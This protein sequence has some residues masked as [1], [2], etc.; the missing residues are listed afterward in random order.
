MPKKFR[1]FER[2]RIDILNLAGVGFLTL[3]LVAVVSVT[4][5]PQIKQIFAPK[6]VDTEYPLD[7]SKP[8]EIIPTVEPPPS[9]SPTTN[10]FTLDQVI[11]T[12]NHT[13]GTPGYDCSQ[14]GCGAGSGA[15]SGYY[16][17]NGRYYAIGGTGNDP[18]RYASTSLAAVKANGGVVS[19]SQSTQT[20][21]QTQ[22]QTTTGGF[23]KD[24]VINTKA[25]ANTAGY[26]M[27]NGN[28]AGY[29]ESNGRYYP[30]GG[31]NNNPIVYQNT[32]LATIKAEAAA[33]AEKAA[34]ANSIAVAEKRASDA[35]ARIDAA[36]K[37]AA[38]L[39]AKQS[40]ITVNQ[41]GGVSIK[42]PNGGTAKYSSDCESGNS[43][44]GVCQAATTTSSLPANYKDILNNVST[45][46][47]AKT[48]NTSPYANIYSTTPGFSPYG[49]LTSTSVFSNYTPSPTTNIQITPKTEQ[50]RLVET[51]NVL[52]TITFG[53]FGNYVGAYQ[54]VA[55]QNP[56]ASYLEQSFSREGLVASTKLGTVITAEGAAIA[57]L[58]G[59]IAA[60]TTAAAGGSVL[61][62]AGAVG[63]QALTTFGAISTMSQ[64]MNAAG[65]HIEDPGSTEAW[66]QTGL[67]ALS[68]LNLGSADYLMKTFSNAASTAQAINSAKTLNTAVSAVNLAV[69]VPTAYSTCSQEG[70]SA[71]DCGGAITAVVA[72]VG[73]GLLDFKQGQLS[74]G[75]PLSKVTDASPQKI[76]ASQ[77]DLALLAKLE[78]ESAKVP[79]ISTSPVDTSSTPIIPEQNLVVEPLDVP[80]TKLPET[81]ITP[82]VETDPNL[83]TKMTPASDLPTTSNVQAPNIP[84]AKVPEAPTMPVTPVTEAVTPVT[85]IVQPTTDTQ[86]STATKVK[87]F[88]VDNWNKITSKPEKNVITSTSGIEY[89]NVKPIT[90]NTTSSL[91]QVS[92]GTDKNGNQSVIKIFSETQIPGPLGQKMKDA[93]L[94][95]IEVL[96]NYS[97]TNPENGVL[98]KL[99]DTITDKTGA[100]KGYVMEEI[101]GIS[102]GDLYN[103]QGQRLTT[104]Q[105]DQIKNTVDTYHKVT[106]EM[107]ADLIPGSSSSQYPL[108]PGNIIFTGDPKRPVVLIDPSPGIPGT[109]WFQPT[110]IESEFKKLGERL[111]DV[112]TAP[113]EDS[114]LTTLIGSKNSPS[115][116][117]VATSPITQSV[118]ETKPTT[119]I[120]EGITDW[121]D[122]N[123]VQP[124]GNRIFGSGPILENL[125]APIPKVPP[126]DVQPPK[127]TLGAPL[128]ITEAE[129]IARLKSGEPAVLYHSLNDANDLKAIKTEGF[130]SRGD[131]KIIVGEKTYNLTYF[132]DV[133]P[134]EVSPESVV[135]EVRNLKLFDGRNV[136]SPPYRSLIDGSYD[137]TVYDGAIENSVSG[138][139]NSR[140]EVI[141]FDPSKSNPSA[142]LHPLSD[143]LPPE[144][145]PVTK[146]V[147]QATPTTNMTFVNRVSNYLDEKIVQPINNILPGGPVKTSIVSETST[148]I[149]PEVITSTP[150]EPFLAIA[151]PETSTKTWVDQMEIPIN[152]NSNLAKYSSHWDGKWNSETSELTVTPN[153]TSSTQNVGNKYYDTDLATVENGVVVPITDSGYHPLNRVGGRG[154]EFDI[155][156][157]EI[158]TKI[159]NTE[160]LF[161]GVNYEGM[162]ENLSGGMVTGGILNVSLGGERI[163]TADNPDFAFGYTVANDYF[164][165]PTF[166]KPGFVLVIE[167]P[168]TVA[169]VNGAEVII[170]GGISFDKVPYVYEIRPYVIESGKIKLQISADGTHLNLPETLD[171]MRTAP[172]AEFVYRKLSLDEAK[173]LFPEKLAP[174]E[175]PVVKV[176]KVAE[177]IPVA[178]SVAQDISNNVKPTLIQSLTNNSFLNKLVGGASVTI[179]TGKIVADNWDNISQTMT[180]LWQSLPFNKKAAPISPTTEVPKDTFLP[181]VDLL[182]S[183][184]D[185]NV[186]PTS[187]PIQQEAQIAVNQ[188]AQN[189][190]QQTSSTPKVLVMGDSITQNYL[191]PTLSDQLKTKGYSV[192]FVGGR[193]SRG[194]IPSEGHGGYNTQA[195]INSL[196][197]G[198]WYYQLDT[199]TTPP[200]KIDKDTDIVILELGVNDMGSNQSGAT[201]PNMKAIIK[202][203]RED[204]NPNI[205]IVIT[206]VPNIYFQDKDYY[207]EAKYLNNELNQMVSEISTSGSPV[208]MGD[209]YAAN[210]KLSQNTIDGVH[211]NDAGANKIAES[212]VSAIEDNQLI[213]KQ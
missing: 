123:V 110:D 128:N 127:V 105:I 202:K 78:T 32:S 124:I 47:T 182:T 31:T 116:Q 145:V 82:I 50:E 196:N 96:K 171:L 22:N 129:N 81:P 109:T 188:P 20:Q 5:N 135:F 2:G 74:L 3:S 107:H 206:P 44:G 79:E 157:T 55:A 208:V 167:R 103:A 187:Q 67:A 151:P 56:E 100:V 213:I 30:I 131:Y 98:P 75:N 114:K 192:E 14:G 146:P 36:E 68:W 85:K 46:T 28:V 134:V 194:G 73:F 77:E 7:L 142:N 53:T 94:K 37:A 4:S 49:N 139:S 166:D 1:S 169:K 207:Q 180:N 35:L 158:P 18:N 80:T 42:V 193:E 69:D 9:I 99:I 204:V 209:S 141:I 39:K 211:P 83:L 118:V 177:T 165:I 113:P 201:V 70:A 43:V 24:Q 17:S 152:E 143:V 138:I 136:E 54:N 86:P 203:L 59:V 125:D 112:N 12:A 71:L 179:L 200:V 140:T 91:S 61:T 163:F 27:S 137:G 57:A 6:A 122:R 150:D 199:Y 185:S 92:V 115:S 38:E 175:L 106:G 29:Y 97:S 45:T 72:D 88:F 23:T 90:S 108:H 58:P 48:T 144:A 162:Q 170:D 178:E 120:A 33:A 84:T 26:L 93:N 164:D 121:W 195:V 190:Q 41:Q 11:N 119:N 130:V 102:L 176:P 168:G 173:A 197:A 147:T 64:T 189:T 181:A 8:Q 172:K 15:V 126:T 95:Q 212:I 62:A 149:V 148:S 153:T 87:D 205:K 198:K 63:A 76:F 10:S 155:P 186:F 101:S 191:L 156:K 34:K 117:N 66:N 13:P 184:D 52:N 160:L 210:Y 65:A 104:E 60:G 183:G 21:T 159:G 154:N 25:A 111:S 16:E 40:I 19:D 133:P 174:V 161:R 132:S 51:Y 89:S